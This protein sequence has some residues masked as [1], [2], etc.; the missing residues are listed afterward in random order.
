MS[1]G[2]WLKTYGL[3]VLKDAAIVLGVAAQDVKTIAPAGS[4]AAT[5]AEDT[6]TEIA[7]IITDVE[8]E[9]AALTPGSV[10]A[11]GASPITGAQKLQMAVARANEKLQKWYQANLPNSPKVTNSAAWQQGVTGIVNGMVSI[12]NSADGTAVQV[13]K[14]V[15]GSSVPSAATTTAA[16]NPP[17]KS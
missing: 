9:V 3:D 5:S 16:A 11:A 6:L 17:A 13:K 8:T 7:T 1:V 10:G 15:E 4:A 12:L 2:T 14:G